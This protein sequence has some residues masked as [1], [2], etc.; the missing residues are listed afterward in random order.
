MFGSGGKII[1]TI[2]ATAND[3]A[4]IFLLLSDFHFFWSFSNNG[5]HI[6]FDT[7]GGVF[8]DDTDGPRRTETDQGWSTSFVGEG[9]P[10]PSPEDWD[11]RCSKN[12]GDSLFGADTDPEDT[13]LGLGTIRK[14]GYLPNST[15]TQDW[16]GNF[17]FEIR[18]STT[19][20]V[21]ATD[22]INITAS[23]EAA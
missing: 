7:D 14:F 1:M 18:N 22:T 5:G 23:F 9:T 17:T 19:L 21:L 11:I 16:V 15:P 8:T 13:W 2:A 4:S 6:E 10:L 20:A 3:D 12:S